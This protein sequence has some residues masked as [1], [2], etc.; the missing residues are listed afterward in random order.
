MI[1]YLVQYQPDQTRNRANACYL[2]KNS[3]DDYG[4]VTNFDVTLFDNEGQIHQLGRIAIIKKGMESGSTEIP[5][6]FEKL[7]DSYC[8]LGQDREFYSTLSSLTEAVQ[9]DFLTGI[10]DCVFNP[11]IYLEFQDEDG[12]KA[13]LLRSVSF[14]DVKKNFSRI[15][16]GDSELTPYAFK[17]E[18]RW[19]DLSEPVECTFAVTPDSLPPSN[20]HVLIGKNGIGKTR[21]LAGMADALTENKAASI[22][23]EGTF[24][25]RSKGSFESIVSSASDEFLNVVVVSYSVFDKF[26]PIRQGTSRST[27]G[28]PYQYVGIKDLDDGGEVKLQNSSEMQKSFIAA[29]D[30]IY[31][32]PRKLNRWA[33]A[34]DVLSSDRGIAEI[35]S[36]DGEA[37]S[38]ES[39]AQHFEQS[40]SG[41]KIVLLTMAKL[42]ELVSERTLVLIDE[43]ETHLHPPLLGS[44]I[45]AISGL[46]VARNGVAIVATHSPVVLQEVPSDCVWSIMRSGSS[47]NISRPTIE[48]FAE[49][50]GVLTRKIFGLEVA[51][52]GFFKLLSDEAEH[53]DFNDVYYKFGGKVGGEGRALIR[54]ITSEGQGD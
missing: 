51:E 45:R 32:D 12:M 36:M 11:H 25:F 34:I 30:E 46:L 52:S 22:G 14:S 53:A 17:Y 44:F 23:L 2:V 41:H 42:V 4:F 6:T 31:P 9:K 29:L 20:I 27:G 3:W 7:D 21:L 33:T 50:V 28:V 38:I 43:P 8:G 47:L 18:F 54:A 35:G 15:L 1:F 10:R 40:S 13:S 39:M 49:N 26:D 19:D 37:S 16:N 24:V 48:T 5:A